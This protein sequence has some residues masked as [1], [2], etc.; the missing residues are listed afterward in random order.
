MNV[1]VSNNVLYRNLSNYLSALISED[2]T[3]SLDTIIGTNMD[4]L[5][6]NLNILNT[7]NTVD[8]SSLTTNTINILQNPNVDR[9]NFINTSPQQL[10]N[11]Y[12]NFLENFVTNQ[13]NFPSSENQINTLLQE[14]LQQSNNYKHVLSK[15]GKKEIC[16][17]KY[18]AEKY[19][20]QK[21]CPISQK[22]FTENKSIIKLPCN[23]IFDTDMIL[24][25][26]E[27][28]NASCPV[29]RYKLDSE[30]EKIKEDGF[31]DHIYGHNNQISYN[32]IVP[33]LFNSYINGVDNAVD[34]VDAVV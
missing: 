4:N 1:D 21:S 29:C 30:E 28:E 5:E 3:E 16:E 12:G 7:T 15:K 32:N 20:E 6:T 14:T 31:G 25:W 34:T 11:V 8:T 27:N 24:N 10:N 23:H 2:I 19:P 26:L 33:G 22:K 18:S 9:F 13:I 17:E